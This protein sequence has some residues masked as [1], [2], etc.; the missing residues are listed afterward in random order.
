MSPLERLVAALKAIP[1][2]PFEGRVF[3][4]V[5]PENK[6]RWPVCIYGREGGALITTMGGTAVYQACR[7]EV[8]GTDYAA[9]VSAMSEVV[10]ALERERLLHDDPD[11][12]SDEWV[13]SLQ[14]F[15]TTIRIVLLP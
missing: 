3:P 1:G 10:S 15:S 5:L 11:P 8:L 13:D 7:I 9:V 4:L 6:R 12:P 2:D 14:A